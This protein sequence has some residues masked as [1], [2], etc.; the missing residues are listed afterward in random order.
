[1]SAFFYVIAVALCLALSTEAPAEDILASPPA[2]VLDG[3]PPVPARL[4][5]D[6]GRYT[7]FKPTAFSSWH[8]QRLE[9]LIARRHKNTTQIHRLSAPGAELELRTDY[10]E[11]VRSASYQPTTGGYYLFGKDSG[12]NEVFRL[13]RSGNG[14]SN[15]AAVA[16]SPED[17]RVQ[18]FAWSNRGDRVVYTTVP[19]NR[20]GSD[21]RVVSEVHV[22]NPLKPDRDKVIAELPGGGWF[23]FTWSPDDTRLVYLE[24]VSVNESYLWIMDV[25][26]G[27][28][29]RLTEKS[30]GEP[31]LYA[32]T[33]FSR[34]G[35]GLY[36]VTDRGTEFRTLNYVDLATLRHTPLS[37]DIQWDV[38]DFDLSHDGK[39][40]AFVTNEDGT[41]VLHVMRTR[42]RKMLPVPRLPLG[43]L[44]SV[45][46][47]RDSVNLAFSVTSAKSPSDVY[48]LNAVSGKLT[49]WT[50]HE[51]VGVDP[52][53]FV[54][55]EL[56]RWPSFDGRSI[57]GFLYR[58][59]PNR[60][61][62]KRPVLVNI[63]GGPESQFRP[64]FLARLNY[65]IDE[66]GISVLFPNVR[67]SSGYGKAFL[68]LDNGRL[69]EDSVKDIGALLDWIATQPDL[70]ASRIMVTGGSYGGYMSLAVSTLYADRIAASVSVVGIS[71]F[72]TF[73]ERTESYRRDLRRA[74]YGDERDPEM[75]K[76]LEGIAP[77]H[78]AE[79]ISKPLFVVQ[80]KNDPR[81]PY[82]EAEQI[83]AT[84]K[85]R[86]TPVWYMLANDEG[87]GFAKKAN[88][89]YQFYS[90]VGFISR[91]LLGLD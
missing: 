87:H 20:K 29:R 89:D 44:D 64:W 62:G 4:A 26:S 10:A 82:T 33:K 71:N 60:F 63:H 73:L 32:E 68:K 52:G 49:R 90:T 76:F 91:H 54:E 9:M 6:V 86:G 27:K 65:H 79:R 3:L 34:D 16:I 58:A 46:W 8:P 66:Q 14:P 41:G 15:A 2:L 55:P 80:G 84:L 24:Y 47:H 17:R 23:G 39:R 21:D 30:S 61:P 11:P 5:A 25:A 51:P 53:A 37:A 67:G 75:R 85:N 12:G 7:E 45:N 88:A 36:T 18:S 77:L 31:V 40:I 13:H 74:E 48:S 22:A 72:V 38:E 69:R 83:V 59:P 35:K 81:V 19:V 1:M 43:T 50:R 57:S 28:R 78:R 70:D 56:V 42:D